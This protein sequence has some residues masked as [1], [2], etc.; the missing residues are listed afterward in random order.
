[1]KNQFYLIPIIAILAGMLL[2]ALKSARDQANTTTCV[3]NLKQLGLAA[4]RYCDDNNGWYSVGVGSDSA[5]SNNPFTGNTKNWWC[6]GCL[7]D[8]IKGSSKNQ[9][10]TP[11]I[12]LCP[13]GSRKTFGVVSPSSEN[14]SY[15]YNKFLAGTRRRD[16][17]EKRD[18]VRNPAGRMVLSEL[19]YDGWKYAGPGTRGWGTAQETRQYYFA[20]R[21]KKKSG[22]N[23]IDGHVELVPYAKVPS[24]N[25]AAKDPYDFFRTH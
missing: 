24:G 25:D 19:G 15:G 1:M 23:Y 10:G 17:I 16:D 11:K 5:L 22:V 21:H 14:F 2:P 18:R 9:Y 20:F 8:Y 13:M 7:T 6:S 4:A 12:I 3:N